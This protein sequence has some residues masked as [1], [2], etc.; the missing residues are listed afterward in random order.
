MRAWKWWR[1]FRNRGDNWGVEKLKSY[2]LARDVPV[3]NTNKQGL[4]NLIIF[5]RKLGLKVD[6]TVEENQHEV[7]REL[8][9]KLSLE[10]GRIILPDSDTL[11]EGWE[12]NALSYPELSQM[13]AE[14]YWDE[15]ES[16]FCFGTNSICMASNY[17]LVI[18][19]PALNHFINRKRSDWH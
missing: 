7:D 18:N 3:G 16:I 9:R 13:N 1:F 19:W 5:A 17:I 15:S 11:S 4:L 2:L 14:K 6:K 8:L 12:E 10:E